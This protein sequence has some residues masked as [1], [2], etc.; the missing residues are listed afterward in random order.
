MPLHLAPVGMTTALP[1][2]PAAV[3][4]APPDAAVVVAPPEAAV[5]AVVAAVVALPELLLLS[6]PHA[7]PTKA[8]PSRTVPALASLVF[9]I[10]WVSPSNTDDVVRGSGRS[11]RYGFTC[12]SARVPASL[13]VD[14]HERFALPKR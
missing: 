13:R 4:A 11:R 9:C 6:L 1:L 7:A 5:V 2:P 12:T 14:R 10:V 3:V 8:R